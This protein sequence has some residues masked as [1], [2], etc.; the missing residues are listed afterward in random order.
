MS[1]IKGRVLQGFSI[2]I[3]IAFCC[4]GNATAETDSFV[5][6]HSDDTECG[7]QLKSTGGIQDQ[8]V[9]HINIISQIELKAEDR[10][11]LNQEDNFIDYRYSLCFGEC[12]FGSVDGVSLSWRGQL[13]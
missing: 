1:I 7:L 8:S 2:L 13:C 11:L 4:A 5:Y 3:F 6:Y 10:P 12:F 9:L